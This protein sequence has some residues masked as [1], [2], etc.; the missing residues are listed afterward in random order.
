MDIL[1]VCNFY[2]FQF[3]K[4]MVRLIFDW[5]IWVDQYLEGK[6]NLKNLLFFAATIGISSFWS[7]RPQNEGAA[8]K[9]YSNRYDTSTSLEQGGKPASF[10]GSWEQPCSE[11]AQKRIS[12]Q[13]TIQISSGTIVAK[14]SFYGYDSNCQG[15]VV[16][17]ELATSKLVLEGPSRIVNGAT[18]LVSTLQGISIMPLD[19]LAVETFK[20]AEPSKNWALNISTEKSVAKQPA[21][22]IIK[23]VDGKLCFGANLDILPSTPELRPKTLEPISGCAIRK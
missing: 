1:N 21:Y 8:A 16:W 9:E 2:D 14:T 18:N 13:V 6:F 17:E 20:K 5:P 19:E 23:I 22:S 4:K 3:I 10:N 15:K 12:E 7:C 11:N